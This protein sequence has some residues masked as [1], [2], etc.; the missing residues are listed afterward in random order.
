VSPRP[1][2]QSRFRHSVEEDV[3]RMQKAVKERGT[4]LSQTVYLGTVGLLFVLPVVGGAYLGLWLDGL[5]EPYAS[6]WT[7]SMIVL[8]V[9]VGAVNVY[10]FIREKG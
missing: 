8:G 3:R 7:P 6:R 2:D 5:R 9:V 1:D 4:L 10:Y